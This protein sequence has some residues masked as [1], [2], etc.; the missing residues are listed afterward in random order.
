MKN[1]VIYCR[2]NRTSDLSRLNQQTQACAEFCQREGLAIVDIYAD[3]GVSGTTI[4]QACQQMLDACCS[5]E[6]RVQA[7]VVHSPDR[8]TRRID[9]HLQ[10][11]L[12]LLTAGIDIYCVNGYSPKM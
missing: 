12:Q 9:L 5:S 1:A 2:T 6:G 4:G 7:I 10:I 8:L 3:A 11:K